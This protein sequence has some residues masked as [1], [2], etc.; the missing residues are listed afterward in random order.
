MLWPADGG[1]L[2]A[3]MKS[4]RIIIIGARGQLGLELMARYGAAAQAWDLPEFDLSREDDL[5]ARLDEER[6]DII[7]NA[8]AYTA[9]DRAEEEP[10]A[11]FQIN[12]RAP[13][14]MAEWADK[15]DA[16]LLHLSTDYVF[17]GKR[18]VGEAYTEED[19]PGPHSVYGR[20]KYEGE[21]AV[22]RLAPQAAV[23]RTAWLYSAHGKNFLR[24]ILRLAL[25]RPERTLRIVND[26]WGCPTGA[27]RLAEQVQCIAERRLP[28]VIH[29]VGEGATTWYALARAWFSA[30][31]LSTSMAP[32]ATEDY[33]T[34]AERPV[35]S[36]LENSRLKRENLCIM[37]P[38]KDDV[39]AFAVQY[40]KTIIDELRS[41][42]HA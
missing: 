10:D 19:T 13:A 16:Y 37:R 14:L 24:T 22:L 33:P 21:Q 27:H 29:A 41:A 7:V 6:P 11:A 15:A 26:Q 36:V 25:E 32:C 23:V 31:N 5:R 38:W 17:D 1:S 34:A 20:S 35:N 42:S 39:Q 40:G 18:P 4:K 2:S 28:G 30:L 8:A 3:R 12:A 9:V